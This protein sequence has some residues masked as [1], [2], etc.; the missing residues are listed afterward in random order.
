[1]VKI[2]FT[3]PRDIGAT[4]A[5]NRLLDAITIEHG[6]YQYFVDWNSTPDLKL[7]NYTSFKLRKN[8]LSLFFW[9]FFLLWQLIKI[10]PDIIV[11]M[12]I[13]SAPSLLTFR[14]F[15]KFE[16]VYDCRDYFAVSY[17]FCNH[18]SRILRLI[19]IAYSR[20]CV[21]I[22]FPDEYGYKY[23]NTASSNY[24]DI[25]N[26]VSTYGY[27]KER[28]H[29]KVKLG[30]FGYLSEDRNIRAIL[31][32]MEKD[33]TVE[34]HVACNYIPERLRDIVQSTNNV[35]YHGKLTHKQ[36]QK[37]MSQM[38]YCLIMYNPALDNY[39]YIKPTKYYDCL[40]IG[41]PYICSE[42]MI[43]LQNDCEDYSHA[44]K[45][46]SFS[47]ENLCKTEYSE[48][49]ANKFKKYE[50]DIVVSEISKRIVKIIHSVNI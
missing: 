8:A 28:S 21:L 19:D 16:H 18:I 42:G 11:N 43:S 40:A 26:T 3:A 48:I 25:P 24:V 29:G 37:L 35:F 32:Q 12:S 4:P 2:L 22:I 9:Q 6:V 13:L 20:L 46:G 10:R 30:Y 44:Q 27:K 45:Y 33:S 38:D 50:Y 14:I 41:L 17:P 47:T 31:S 36:S 39:K 49:N 7:K 34:L 1:M 15:K 5:L 23:F